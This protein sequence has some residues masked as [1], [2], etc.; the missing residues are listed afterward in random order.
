[1]AKEIGFDAYLTKP[2]RHHQLYQCLCQVMGKADNREALGV[3][4][5]VEE[6]EQIA[7][8]I[9]HSL[10]TRHRLKEDDARRK[11][12]ILL[13]EDNAVNQKVAV[14]ML[15][16]LGCRVDV[17]VNGLEAVEAQARLAYD[18]IIMDCQMPDMDGFE[19]TREIRKREALGVKCEEKVE[20]L[21]DALR[22]SSRSYRCSDGEC[23]E[24]R[25]GEMF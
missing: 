1:M 3:K 21:P 25:P 2:L 9:S 6:E 24:G 12:R 20:V 5:E 15:E 8:D 4:R 16:K 18:A 19:A 13:A 11:P 10:V 7:S 14:K 17:V 22:K 23:D